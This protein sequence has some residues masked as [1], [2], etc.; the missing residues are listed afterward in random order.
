MPRGVFDPCFE[1]RRGF[2]ADLQKGQKHIEGVKKA[3]VHVHPGVHP[4][5]PEFLNIGK[6]FGV[7]GLRRGDKGVG[8]GQSGVILAPGG[9][10]LSR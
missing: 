9:R 7:K 5:L 10:G 2:F 4:R 6:G 8:R 3:G 1:G